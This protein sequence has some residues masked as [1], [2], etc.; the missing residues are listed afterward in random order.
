MSNVKRK[1]LVYLYYKLMNPKTSEENIP[2]WAYRPITYQVTHTLKKF[3]INV[4]APNCVF[5]KL[6]RKMYQ[7]SGFK[8]GKKGTIGMKCYFDDTCIEQMEIGDHV[9]ISYGVYFS[10]HGKGQNHNKIIIRDRAYIGMRATILARNDIEIGEDS[11]I[12]AMTFVNK[13]VPAG[14]TV[15][16]VPFKIIKSQE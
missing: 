13:S 7:W 6:R 16:G 8:I 11:T 4:I 5:P 1:G 2:Q 9:V 14:A 10:C 15:V 3:V 12:G